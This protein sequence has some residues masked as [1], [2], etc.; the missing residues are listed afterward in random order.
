MT[1]RGELAEQIGSSFGRLHY[2]FLTPLIG[3][4]I[5]LLE[6]QNKIEGMPKI[7]G[8]QI[9][10]R[11]VSPLARGMNQE[12]IQNLAGFQ[13]ALLGTVGPQMAGLYVNTDKVVDKIA[14]NFEI[15]SELLTTEKERQQKIQQMGQSMAQAEEAQPGGADKVMSLVAGAQGG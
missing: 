2:E 4:I 10:V 5:Y 9:K 3:R 7:D 1:R 6:Q 15:D 14:K 8:R 12:E 11:S 13:Q